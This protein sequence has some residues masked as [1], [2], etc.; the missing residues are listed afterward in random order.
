MLRLPGAVAEDITMMSSN[1]SPA[2]LNWSSPLAHR[3][4]GPVTHSRRQR[5]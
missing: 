3:Y 2:N 5:E 4:T 1:L